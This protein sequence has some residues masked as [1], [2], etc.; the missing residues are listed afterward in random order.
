MAVCPGAGAGAGQHLQV[1][2][3]GE[4]STAGA[5]AGA[6]LPGDAAPRLPAAARR[7]L[8]GAGGKPQLPGDASALH[9]SSP[10]IF[11]IIPHPPTPTLTPPPV[12]RAVRHH[13]PL[14]PDQSPP[15]LA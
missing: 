13:C 12:T 10:P 1:L 15:S 6:A 7:K 14:A 5:A 8:K 3:A 11:P 2:G 4:R 9:Q